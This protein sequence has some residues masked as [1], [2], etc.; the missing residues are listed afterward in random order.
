M[1]VLGLDGR[2][3]SWNLTKSKYRFGKKKCSKNHKKVRSVLKDLFPHDIILE[4][5]TLPGSTTISRKKPLYADFFLPSQ[6]LIIE[7]H[8]EQHYTYNNFFYKT[9]QAFYKAKARDRDKE[10]WCDLNS[11]DIVVLDHKANEDEWKQ[12]I[13]SR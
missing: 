10:E 8:G 3:Y 5:V 4:E 11:I 6:N 9:K 1:K 12:Q 2:E 7:V 13:N